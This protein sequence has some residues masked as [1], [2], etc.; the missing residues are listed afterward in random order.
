[1]VNMYAVCNTSSI[2]LMVGSLNGWM[3]KSSILLLINASIIAQ[4]PDN[5]AIFCC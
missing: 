4:A 3:F 2:I 1:M 5:Q